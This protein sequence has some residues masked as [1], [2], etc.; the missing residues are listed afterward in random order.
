MIWLWQFCFAQTRSIWKLQSVKVFINFLHWFIN[1]SKLSMISMF[2]VS[3]SNV[4]MHKSKISLIFWWPAI[5]DRAESVV[6]KCSVR[7]GVL[8][9]FAKFTGKHLCHSLFFKKILKR[10]LWH[11]CFPVKFAKFLRTGFLIERPRG[12]FWH[13]SLG[14]PYLQG[15]PTF[16][17]NR[18]CLDVSKDC[19][20]WF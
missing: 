20:R 11:R 14:D 1:V 2:K 9:N 8:R 12:Y 3:T 15:I 4:Q 16:S 17:S 10:R 5:F 19:N 13:S 18:P 7:K 6:Q